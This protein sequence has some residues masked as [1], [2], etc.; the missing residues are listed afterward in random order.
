MPLAI[1]KSTKICVTHHVFR[2]EWNS[3]SHCLA[4]ITDVDGDVYIRERDLDELIGALQVMRATLL[5]T[6]GADA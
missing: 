6:P 1:T 3:V 5:D 2:I 4:I